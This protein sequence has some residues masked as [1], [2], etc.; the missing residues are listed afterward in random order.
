MMHLVDGYLK[1]SKSDIKMQNI[2]VCTFVHIIWIY[3]Q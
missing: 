1:L 2:N 3:P